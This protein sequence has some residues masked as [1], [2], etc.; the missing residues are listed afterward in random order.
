[1][2]ATT[3]NGNY[4]VG[5]TGTP[6]LYVVDNDRSQAAFTIVG[7]PLPH[8]PAASEQNIQFQFELFTP[9]KDG[10]VRFNIPSTNGW[11][12]PSHTDDGAKAGK[13]ARVKL[14]TDAGH[15]CPTRS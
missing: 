6:A 9:I 8:Y 14:V 11:K 15:G 5:D 1:M 2:W 4:V 12:A 13:K 3:L 10:S 7:D